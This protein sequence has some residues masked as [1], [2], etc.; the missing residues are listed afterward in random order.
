TLEVLRPEIALM[1]VACFS[2]VFVFFGLYLGNVRVYQLGQQPAG[3]STIRFLFDFS[4]KRRIFEILL[5]I[6]LV[7]LAYHGAYLLRWDGEMP[8]QQLTILLRTVSL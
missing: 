7:A 8:A 1:P 6:I 4:H 3:M 2:L 5:D